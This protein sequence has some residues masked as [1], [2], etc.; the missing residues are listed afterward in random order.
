MFGAIQHL[1]VRIFPTADEASA[2]GFDRNDKYKD[3]KPLEIKTAVVVKDGTVGHNSTVDLVLEDAE[4]NRYV[5]IL[6]G[7][8]LRG[9][10]A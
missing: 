1:I 10:P 7:T 2:A 9:I 5:A 3:T 6:T 4:G 8:L